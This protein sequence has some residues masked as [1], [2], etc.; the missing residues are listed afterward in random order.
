MM[1]FGLPVFTLP[2]QR[3][4]YRAER[5][6]EDRLLV[7]RAATRAGGRFRVR[8][9]E[10][11]DAAA[12][13]ALEARLFAGLSGGGYDLGL[14]YDPAFFVSNRL[15]WILRI[16]AEDQ[17]GIMAYAIAQVRADELYLY[18]GAALGGR[19]KPGQVLFHTLV[20]VAADLGLTT[21]TTSLSRR[22]RMA[23]LARI[24]ARLGMR[25]GRPGQTL[26]GQPVPRDWL[27]LSGRAAELDA[28]RQAQGE[29][30]GRAQ[31][32]QVSQAVGDREPDLDRVADHHRSVP[33]G[34]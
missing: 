4:P 24:H 11:D 26:T 14:E 3:F 8:L 17:R 19:G 5:R 1:H 18:E 32:Q 23:G 30:Y 34:L 28:R 2:W 16:V 13:A 33:A 21:V 7:A 15:G 12:I 9:A 31:E 10:A 29:D 25:P 20:A 22:D 27:W 6:E